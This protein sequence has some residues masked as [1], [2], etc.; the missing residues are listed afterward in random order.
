MPCMFLTMTA[1]EAS[2]A[3]SRTVTSTIHLDG[4]AAMDEDS[5]V[6][7]AAVEA[8]AEVAAAEETNGMAAAVTAAAHSMAQIATSAR[9]TAGVITRATRK[10]QM[11]R[12]LK[13]KLNRNSRKLKPM[14]RSSWLKMSE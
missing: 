1:I 5:A 7:V 4:T 6:A 11:L 10:E 13:T 3:S 14:S 12:F 9:K 8:V 2:D